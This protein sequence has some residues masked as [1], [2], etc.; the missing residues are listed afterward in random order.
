[1]LDGISSSRCSVVSGVPQGTVL[2]LTLFSV[3]INDLHEFI[4][5][6]SIKLFADDCIIYKAIHASEDVEKLQEDPGALQEWQ[7]TWLMKLNVSIYFAMNA[8]CF[9]EQVK[10]LLPT[11][12][13]IISFVCGTLQVPG[14]HHLE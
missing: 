1:M 11:D 8:Y 4:L 12:C 3:Y 9:L 13:P 10:S 2:G 7:Q 5:H 14:C 6:S